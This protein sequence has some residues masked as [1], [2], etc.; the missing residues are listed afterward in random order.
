MA[1]E[2]DI[3][4]GE[5]AV[6]FLSNRVVYPAKDSVHRDVD[7]VMKGGITSG[8]VY[9]LAV[10]ELARTRR[11]RSLGGSSAGGI[12][13]AMAAAA[14]FARD[15]GGFKR[16]ALLPVQLGD[17]LLAIFQPSRGTKPL[18]DVLLAPLD[19]TNL[20]PVKVVVAVVR[21]GLRWFLLALAAVLLVSIGALVLAGAEAR[22][23]AVGVVPILLVPG[24]ALALMAATAG[25]VLT[26]R[27]KLEAN[28]YGLCRGSAGGASEG[29]EPF[30]DWLHTKL[31]SVSGLGGD[32]ILTFGHLWGDPRLDELPEHPAIRLEMM[33]TNVTHCRPVRLPFES[34]LYYYCPTELGWYFPQSIVAHV[35]DHGRPSR[36][37]TTWTCPDHHVPLAHLPHPGKMPVVVAVRMT[38]SFPVLIS[39]VP[40]FAVD[41][42]ADPQHPVRCWFSDGGISSNFPIHFFDALW[43]KHPTYGISLGPYPPGRPR[44]AVYL[45]DPRA[46]ARP[47]VRDT[48][49]LIGFLRAML[50]TL[51]NWS[52]EGQ[53]TLPGYGD[54]IVEVRHTDAEG[55]INLNMGRDE[56]LSLCFRGY[57]AAKELERFDFDRHRW[58]RYRTAMAELDEATANMASK[59]DGD[60]PSGE[61]GYREFVE[62]LPKRAGDDPGKGWR[63]AAVERTDVLL[64]FAGRGDDG[65]RRPRPPDFPSKE[66]GP[67]PDL[68]IVAHF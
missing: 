49:T 14:E 53:S 34:D 51:Q 3:T 7:M 33:T 62:H 11:F 67:A 44:R 22:R 15:S 64:A 47:R 12:A 56:V 4:T 35:L 6:D 30:T 10:C 60:L 63:S 5:E 37:G 52:D 17:D 54:R 42:S 2:G 65:T 59:Y 55:G 24:L 38:L 16:L 58:V 45:R 68:R 61:P 8:V 29:V 32:E 26:G 13:A 27:R 20:R 40:L 1:E 18:F 50:D 66:P 9:P 46:T 39:A 28:G 43:P 19:K 21:G 25:L 23:L 41:R 31:Q 57:L 36:S 48:G